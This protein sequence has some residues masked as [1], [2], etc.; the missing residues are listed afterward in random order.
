MIIK[1]KRNKLTIY[2]DYCFDIQRQLE[3]LLI[4]YNT[5][6]IVTII[7]KCNLIINQCDTYINELRNYENQF[8]DDII[9]LNLIQQDIGIFELYKNTT[10]NLLNNITINKQIIIESTKNEL[11]ILEQLLQEKFKRKES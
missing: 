1:D 2:S 4:V 3:Q 6:S 11:L 5:D 10:K 9:S 8:S 7:L